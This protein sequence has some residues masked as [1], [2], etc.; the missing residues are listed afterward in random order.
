MR[1][2]LDERVT[3]QELPGFGELLLAQA[4]GGER[5]T[6]VVDALWGPPLVAALFFETK[7]AIVSRLTALLSA[8]LLV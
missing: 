6:Y 3:G 2:H 7:W 8:T 4:F 1:L 5:P